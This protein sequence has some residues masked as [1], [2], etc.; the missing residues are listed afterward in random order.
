MQSCLSRTDESHPIDPSVLPG[1]QGVLHLEENLLH[2]KIFPPFIR[3]RAGATQ[4]AIDTVPVTSL[5]RDGIN[6]Q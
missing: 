6:S 5:E 2:R 3:Q 1:R 4:L